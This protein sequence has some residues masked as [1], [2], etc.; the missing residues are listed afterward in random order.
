MSYPNAFVEA[1]K[2]S[3]IGV[4][5]ITEVVARP[6]RLMDPDGCVGVYPGDWLPVDFET[7]VPTDEP[8][9]SQ[10]EVYIQNMSKGAPEEAVRELHSTLTRRVRAMLYQDTE[11]RVALRE[12]NEGGE[13]F[14]RF[15][16]VRQSYWNNEA[17]GQF[18]CLAQTLTHFETT[19]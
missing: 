9:I 10:Y 13:R 16:V 12:L 7:G 2:A 14:S 6:L 19:L 1:I 11:L 15:K 5:G 3:V 18:V 4:E 17:S 8:A